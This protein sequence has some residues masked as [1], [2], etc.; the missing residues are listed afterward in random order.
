MLWS[1]N[2]SWSGNFSYINNNTYIFNINNNLSIKLQA[3]NINI[4]NISFVDG[5]NT[6]IPI[7]TGF[8]LLDLT[9][10]QVVAPSFFGFLYQIA[11][12]CDYIHSV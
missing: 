4:A 10:N 3:V 7:P 9:N 11:W 8:V 6:V 12:Q 5:N 1:E 2:F